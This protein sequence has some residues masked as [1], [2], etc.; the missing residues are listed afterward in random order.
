MRYAQPARPRVSI[1][2]LRAAYT[3]SNPQPKPGEHPIAVFRPRRELNKVVKRGRPSDVRVGIVI[4][5]PYRA[6]I[7]SLFMHLAYEYLALQEGVVVNRFV[8]SVE[9]DI[10][11]SL[12]HPVGMRDMD[13]L[14]ISTPFELDYVYA[15]RALMKEGVLRNPGKTSVE[16]PIKIVG[17]VAP[18]ANPLP[19]APLF[20]AVVLGDAEPL[21]NRLP[22]LLQLID[23]RDAFLEALASVDGVYVPRLG[24]YRV[25]KAVVHDLNTS[26]HPV[27]Q[28]VPLDE[29]PVYGRGVMIEAS[30]G[31]PYTC[32]F[33]LEGFATKPFRYR[34]VATL[35]RVIEKASHATELRHVVFYSLSLFSVPGIDRVLEHLV[36]TGF[37]ASIPSVRIDTLNERRLR[38]I[39]EL[40]QRTLTIAPES[41]VPGVLRLLGKRVEPSD[42]EELVLEA[43]A[44]GLTKV[45]IYLITG[46]SRAIDEALAREAPRFA[47]RV[48]RRAGIGR[49][50]LRFSVN[51]LI[52]KPGTPLQWLP[53]R[54]VL[55]ARASLEKVGRALRRVAR[56]DTYDVWWGFAQAVIGLGD[57]RVSRLIEEWAL[58]G[59]GIGG[60]KKAFRSL[61]AELDF[62]E[63]GWGEPPWSSVVESPWGTETL[64][65]MFNGFLESLSRLE[66]LVSGM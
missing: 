21:L 39:A 51:P 63:K 34:S 16:R 1:R 42:V 32:P 66:P 25:K 56:V 64:R 60:F 36:D 58:Y 31:C 14:L 44:Q 65:A 5:L 23:D 13:L 53:P 59:I 9:D 57:E 18:S 20:D 33:C 41:L 49:D 52:P 48:R 61:S 24:R 11:E 62:V 27:K 30:R 54:R 17:G 47:E 26:H 22:D 37:T 3:P 45:K 38:L 6:A 10:V 7:N 29:E 50:S 40:G 43:F 55:E 35:L 15:A 19:I 46:L 8:Y 12:E 2:R 4:P 28:L